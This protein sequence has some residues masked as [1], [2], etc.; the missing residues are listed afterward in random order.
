[1]EENIDDQSSRGSA[2]RVELHEFLLRKKFDLE[3]VLN[4]HCGHFAK[5]SMKMFSEDS[6]N[7]DDLQQFGT[8]SCSGSAPFAETWYDA[9]SDV[10][11]VINALEPSFIAPA[12]HYNSY[13]DHLLRD[14]FWQDFKSRIPP[15]DRPSNIMRRLSFQVP[16]QSVLLAVKSGLDRLVLLLSYYYRGFSPNTT[17]GRIKNDGRASGLMA[18]ALTNAATDP[19]FRFLVDDYHRWIKFAV[20]PR[21]VITHHNDMMAEFVFDAETGIELPI[22]LGK[23]ILPENGAAEPSGASQGWGPLSLCDVCENWHSLFDKTL[24]ELLKRDLAFDR[25]KMTPPPKGWS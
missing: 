20:E 22:L 10:I 13:I 25:S 19:I 2:A 24:G 3:S 17:F 15:E 6:R 5:F 4:V 8:D 11:T 12:W 21:D 9:R 23:K 7:S 16:A 14:L 1:V 18:Y